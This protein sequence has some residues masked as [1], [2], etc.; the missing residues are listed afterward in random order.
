MIT[1]LLLGI[2]LISFSNSK[3]WYQQVLEVQ[4][5]ATIPNHSLLQNHQEHQANIQQFLAESQ[6]DIR[7]RTQE[8]FS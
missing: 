1:I 4:T 5:Y 6:A 8:F 3:S 7:F 2:M